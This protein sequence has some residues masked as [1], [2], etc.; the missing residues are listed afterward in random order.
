MK[1][2]SEPQLVWQGVTVAYMHPD[3]IVVELVQ[4]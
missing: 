2:H 3:G 4:Y 1:F